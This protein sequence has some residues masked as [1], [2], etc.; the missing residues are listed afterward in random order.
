M[1]SEDVVIIALG[2]ILKVHS[3]SR[4][5]INLIRANPNTMSTK[6]V[7]KE[8][9]CECSFLKGLR[10]VFIVSHLSAKDKI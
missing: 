8:L 10:T 4:N 6:L 3:T 5:A 7:I 2:S 1:E 9:A